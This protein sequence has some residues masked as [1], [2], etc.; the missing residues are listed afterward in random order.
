MGQEERI[1]VLDDGFVRLDGAMA[2]DLSVVNAARVS[3]GVRKQ[4]MDERDAGLIRFLMRES[5]GTPFEHNAFRFHV[6]CPIFVARE[7]FRHRVGCLAAETRIAFARPTERADEVWTRHIADLHAD[8]AA[9]DRAELADAPLRVLDEAAGSFT[10]GRIADVV[11]SGVRPVYDVALADG[12][13]IAMTADHRVLT[14]RGWQTLREAVGLVGSGERAVAT[15]PV[16]LLVNGVVAPPA[17]GRHGFRLLAHPVAVQRVVH[18]GDEET[19]DLCVEGPWH[20]FVANGIVVHNSF[21]ELSGRYT[22]LPDAFYVP[23]PEDVR[24]QV[25]KPGA[26]TFETLPDD[27]AEATRGRMSDAYAAAYETYRGLLDDGVAKEVARA[28]LP[29][30]IY[31]EFWWTLNARSVMH[32]L[33]LRNAETAQREIR[34]YAEAVEQ[35]FSTRMPVTHAAFVAR[36]RLAP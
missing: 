28:V 19:F 32:F 34:R 24:T 23:S 9:G 4:E 22:E 18:R 30:G 29:V 14:P 20:N 6:R 7:W 2:D 5:H 10:V 13:R 25:G 35:L 11:A 26:Y 16:D 36:G 3:F 12:K 27:V 21:N 31:T 33:G 15:R 1:D 8:W 17:P